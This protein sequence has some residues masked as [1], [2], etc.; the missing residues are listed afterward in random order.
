MTTEGSERFRVLTDLFDEIVALDP[1]A[2][3]QR[4]RDACA[5]APR[6]EAELRALLAADETADAFIVDVVSDEAATLTAPDLDG[7]VLGAWR[8]LEQLGEG[9]MGAVYLAERSDGEYEARAAIKLVRGG[10]PDARLTERFRAERQILAGLS[11]PGVAKLLDG[12]TTEDGTPYLVMELVEG[13]PVT[14]WCDEAGLGIDERLELFVEICD[15]VA[16]A[17]ASLVA[18]RDLKPSNILVTEDGEPKL[19]DF[20]IAKLMED[21]DESGEGLTRTYGVMTPAYASPEQ[22]AGGRAGVAADVY[23]LGVLLFELLSGRLPIETGGLTPA[24]LMASV[25]RE[26]PARVSTVVEDDVSRRRLSGDLDAIVS[27]ALRKEPHERYAS[28]QALADDI[29]LHLAGMPIQAR[30]DDWRYRTGKL[31][32][33][34]AGVV[35]GGLLL[36]ML[37][38]SFTVNAV[39]QARAVARE[40]DRAEAQ[41]VAAEQ[42]SGFLE[43]LFS[44]ADPNQATS[45]D[46]TVR[47]ILDR[48]AERVLTDLE[49][50][51]AIQASL[52]VVLGRVLRAVGE[53]DAAVPLLDSA[54][55]V[56]RRSSDATELERGDALLE[57][58][59]LAYDLGAYP[60][61]VELHRQALTAYRSAGEGAPAQVASALDE[62][63]V[64]LQ[65]EGRLEEA[66]EY[67]GQAVAAY[68]AIDPEPNADLASALVS[69]TDILRGVG[70]IDEALEVIEEGLSMTR[71]VY[72]D[73]HL[74]VAAALNQMASTL[75][76]HGR[77]QEAIELVEEG[78]AIRRAAFDG[79]HVEIAASLGNLANMLASVGRLDEALENRRASVDMVREIFPGDHPYVAATTHS[80]ASL[81]A[82]MGRMDEAEDIFEESVRAHRA[83]FPADHPNLGYP[84]TGLGR[85]YRD[86]GRLDQAE[87]LLRE[88]YGARA[89]GLPSGHWHVAASGLELGLTLERMDR[90]EEAERFLME[91]HEI[92]ADT[93]GPDDDRTV[94]ARSALR[95]HLERRGLS[96]RAE[97]LAGEA[98]GGS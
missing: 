2:R 87:A 5:D 36:L 80:L 23:S 70:R 13:L 68:R 29:R 37:G 8:I 18:H 74:E 43:D 1:G 30:R 40:R 44:E 67:S 45:A 25:T 4:I 24:Q 31:L 69:Y 50:E 73:Q 49:A 89:G 14:E 15:A 12:G 66:V 3:E 63:S 56:R 57:R 71:A 21:M 47:E 59:R 90:D 42:V 17:H 76:E 26:V 98:G 41:R 10:V 95:Q 64:S 86:S 16:H 34:N 38:I 7:R 55:A 79:P 96:Q 11:H 9:G 51:P 46:V 35:S 52:A 33:R 78:L 53:Y 39:L 72:G 91:A 75:E 6:L 54:L 77:A 19:L 22:I 61:A 97:A 94:R 81:L 32:R 88:A 48:G 58:G 82:R 65:E 83:V 28:V 92:L 93:F 20:G 62:L 27:R 84:L 60:E 85:I